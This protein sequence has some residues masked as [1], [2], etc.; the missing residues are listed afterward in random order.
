MLPSGSN[1]FKQTDRVAIYLEVYEPSALQSPPK[2]GLRMRVLDKATGVAKLE[3]NV[4][5]TAS[6]VIPGNPVIPMGVPLPVARLQP[7]NYV[8]EL[9]ATDSAGNASMA[10]KVE[11]TVE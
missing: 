11:F 6:S 8:V 10:R 9:R 2:V 3:A 1:R 4:P 7:G 5:D